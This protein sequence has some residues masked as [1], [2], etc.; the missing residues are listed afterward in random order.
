MLRA[1]AEIPILPMHIYDGSLLAGGALVGTG[2]WKFA[3]NKNGV[4]HLDAQRQVLGRP[5]GDRRHRVRATS[6]MPRSR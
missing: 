4:V 5:A 1:L 6:P 3:S 2:P